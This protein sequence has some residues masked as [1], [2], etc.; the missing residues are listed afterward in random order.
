[1]VNESRGRT[2]D[3]KLRAYST[4]YGV[5]RAPLFST[6]PEVTSKL[7]TARMNHPGEWIDGAPASRARGRRAPS[8]AAISPADLEQS[9]SPH[10]ATDAHRDNGVAR[11]EAL[12]RKQRMPRQPRSGHSERMA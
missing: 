1:M 7:L 4:N 10:P 11:A 8:R 12:P 6:V 3:T 2:G 5:D 9:G